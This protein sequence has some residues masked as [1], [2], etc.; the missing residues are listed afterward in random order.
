[1]VPDAAEAV[2]EGNGLDG[3][4][5]YFSKWLEQSKTQGEAVSENGKLTLRVYGKSCHAMEPD[6]GINAGL[7]L[8]ECL[9][10]TELDGA[11]KHFV[12]TVS[13]YFLNDTRGKS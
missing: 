11:G 9:N 12:K 10:G 6:N 4:H 2:I 13:D 7:K 5:A 3:V 8:A 1:M